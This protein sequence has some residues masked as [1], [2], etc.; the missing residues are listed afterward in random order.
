RMLEKRGIPHDVLNAKY[1]ER[2][3]QIVA[4]AGQ[5]GAVTIATNMAGRG[6]DIV[7]GDGIADHGGLHI[8]GTER[9]ESRR[10]DNQLRGRSGRHVVEY[11]DVMNEQRKVIYGERRKVLIGVDTRAN[12][13]SY[14]HDLIAD[15]VPGYADDRHR[16]LW[17]L[18][19]LFHHLGQVVPLPPFEQV[20]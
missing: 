15:T 19:G 5:P 7:L 18:E 20:D 4:A 8:V 9:H 14:I 6:T 16:E 3:A 1:H 17:D 11:D 12:V 10:I 13:L 2:E